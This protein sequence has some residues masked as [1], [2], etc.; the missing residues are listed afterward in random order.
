LLNKDIARGQKV[1]GIFGVAVV[2]WVKAQGWISFA[3]MEI[4]QIITTAKTR[5]KIK[6]AFLSAIALALPLALL[7]QSSTMAQV[8]NESKLPPAAA[9]GEGRQIIINKLNSIRFDH[10]FYDGLPLGEVVRILQEEVRKRDPE[11]KGINFVITPN[12]D[13]ASA[14][15][16]EPAVPV[17]PLD[18][19]SITIRINPPLNDVRLVDVLDAVV[20]VAD[21]SIKYSIEDYGVVFTPKGYDSAHK[22]DAGFSF[23]GGTPRQLLEAVEKQCNVNWSDVADIP[24]QIQNVRIPALRIDQESIGPILDNA[25]PRQDQPAGVNP[26]VGSGIFSEHRATPLEALVEKQ[27]QRRREQQWS[28]HRATP[29]EALVVL[30][31]HLGEM[32]PELGRLVVEGDLARPSV[33]MFIP[34]NT[35]DLPEIKV[36]AFPLKGIHKPDWKK[37]EDDIARVEDERVGLRDKFLAGQST[38]RFTGRFE[39]HEAT[40][41]LVAYGPESYIDMVESLVAAHRAN[42]NFL[43]DLGLPETKPAV[44]SNAPKSAPKAEK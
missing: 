8:K 42:Q 38:G 5:M 37:L 21:H 16:G 43:E 27:E 26:L 6:P 13:T 19:N 22:D 44:P 23:P 15:Q 24:A 32:K 33:V 28:E 30:Y 12:G 34:G 11:K 39:I 9:S 4:S 3:F 20:K 2:S 18:M 36:K 17:E 40:S 14:P 10:V 41:L 7:T 35:P 25:A 31:N 29:L 1:R